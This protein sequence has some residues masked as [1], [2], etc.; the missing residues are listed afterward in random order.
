MTPSVA[1]ERFRH[2]LVK[3]DASSGSGPTQGIYSYRGSGTEAISVP[4]K[5]QSEGPELPGTVIDRP[6]GCFEFRLDY[7]SDH[8]QSWT[9]CAWHGGLVTRWWFGPLFSPR[10]GRSLAFSRP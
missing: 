9:Y 6:R 2:E 7:S 10:I 1:V 8:W 5:S 4:P 3:G